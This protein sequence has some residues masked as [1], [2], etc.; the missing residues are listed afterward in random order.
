MPI[1][2]RGF[3]HQTVSMPSIP[4]LSLSNAIDFVCSWCIF[5]F[6]S[7]RLCFHIHP[8]TS[9][10]HA[11]PPP[12]Q[13]PPSPRINGPTLRTW[14]Q[15][16][17]LLAILIAGWGITPCRPWTWHGDFGW[18]WPPIWFFSLFFE[19]KPLSL[20]HG[21][22]NP[23]CALRNLGRKGWSSPLV[24]G[25]RWVPCWLHCT[26]SLGPTLRIISLISP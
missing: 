21:G 23:K 17:W 22:A 14:I 13:G 11:M 3:C 1:P 8:L 19:P 10:M 2:S 26:T 18:N 20:N 4:A 7:H 5:G 6:S 9:P 12:T 16:M 25:K 24:D 15:T